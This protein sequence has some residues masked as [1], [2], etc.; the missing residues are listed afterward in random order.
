MLFEEDV[1][2]YNDTPKKQR[3]ILDELDEIDD[4]DTDVFSAMA[5]SK[6]QV[7][8]YSEDKG[9]K[10]KKTTIEVSD[11]SSPDDS[12][13]DTEWL[14]SIMSFK[15]PKK[16]K[17]KHSKG[18]TGFEI[19]EN[20]EVIKGKKKKGKHKKGKGPTNYRK[21]F[22]SEATML[23]S[24]YT[25]HTKF[26]DGLQRK[27]DVMNNTKS[28]ARGIGKFTTDLIET[29]STA[30][31]TQLSIIK[32]Q[33]ALKSKIADLT[34]KERKE[35][36]TGDEGQSDSSMYASSFMNEILRNGHKTVIENAE[37]GG[38][39]SDEDAALDAEDLAQALNDAM[40]G[41]EM[42]P[43]LEYENENVK[44]YVVCH[45]DGEW[46]FE[47][48]Y[49]NGDVARDYPLPSRSRMSFNKSTMMATDE[50]G[51]RYPLDVA[52]DD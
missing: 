24:L 25:D 6:F 41:E 13:A 30:R 31:N 12:P 34:M 35:F 2:G 42:S 15:S 27:Y 14:D 36:G 1:F 28:S 45:N 23:R 7:K 29:I 11:Y 10:K 38:A 16:K 44:V 48:R 26:V 40:G 51:R 46:D 8:Q 47:A 39:Y 32:E 18:F 33:I 17:L 22:E 3:D 50:H 43:Y 9:K 5:P 20:G 37:P 52:D 21:E 4:T 19:D 49:P